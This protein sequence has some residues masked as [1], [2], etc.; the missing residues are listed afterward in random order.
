L[1]IIFIND[2]SKDSS[3]A[4]LEPVGRFQINGFASFTS[5]ETRGKTAAMMAGFDF[6]QGDVIIP[7]DGDGQNDPA[8][9]SEN[10]E[11]H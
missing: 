6:A 7:L 8:E 5:S 9:Y 4:I 10:A 2:G 3:A 1:E 11:P